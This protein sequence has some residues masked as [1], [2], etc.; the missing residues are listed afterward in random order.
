MPGWLFFES[1]LCRQEGR[2]LELNR[3]MNL[4]RYYT[5][6]VWEADT[7]MHLDIHTHTESKTVKDAGKLEQCRP[8]RAS[9]YDAGLTQVTSNGKGKVGWQE[10]LRL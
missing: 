1:E 10:R 8:R 6:G 7:K 9:D 3:C 2:D 5:V 4:G